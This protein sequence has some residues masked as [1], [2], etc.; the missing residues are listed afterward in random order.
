[1]KKENV[2]YDKAY[3]FAI[4]IVKAYEYLVNN[5]KMSKIADQLLRSGTSIGANLS[6]A[7]GAISKADFSSKVSIAYKECLETKF[8]ISLLKDTNHIDEKT[9]DSIYADPEEIGRLLFA[10]LKT[11]RISPN[12]KAIIN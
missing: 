8:W 7:N 4:M 6:E 12:P 1:M 2:V 9:F 5:K 11:T 10:I 3:K